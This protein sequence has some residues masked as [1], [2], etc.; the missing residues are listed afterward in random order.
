VSKTLHSMERAFT[1]DLPPKQAAQEV[2]ELLSH[3]YL[4]LEDEVLFAI[5]EIALADQQPLVWSLVEDAYG[6]ATF[7]PAEA[8][9]LASECEVL[10]KKAN[11]VAF[12]WLKIVGAFANAVGE[13]GKY[14]CA[15]AD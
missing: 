1:P 11:Q 12:I 15:H 3:S 5:A 10:I 6:G 9:R 14:L 8:Q 7:S 13:Q 4:H 2:A